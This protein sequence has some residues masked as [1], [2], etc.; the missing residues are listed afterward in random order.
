MF[1]DRTDAGKQLLERM[2]TL[3]AAEVVVEALPRGGVPVAEVVAEGLGA[4]LDIVMVRKVGLPGQRE[5]ALAA[6][7]NGADPVLTVNE[8]VSRSA[9]LNIDR[10]W[11]LAEPELRE[12]ARRREL[13]LGGRPA[14]PI[15]GKAV[16][17]VDDGI[18]T[19]A[20]MRASLRHVR[21]RGPARLILAVPVSPADTLAELSAMVD[22]VVCLETPRPFHAVG[23]HYTSF[24]Q[25]SDAAVKSALARASNRMSKKTEG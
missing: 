9:G 2:P 17:V 4:P 11:E 25:V 6:V 3:D 20:T 10:I 19:G 14:I 24:E 5:L 7:T 12:I 1:R 13:Y 22:E 21:A 16:I 15:K 23:V 8:H 18:A